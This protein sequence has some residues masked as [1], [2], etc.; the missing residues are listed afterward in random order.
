MMKLLAVFLYV[1]AFLPT[2]LASSS[3]SKST[4][5]KL[6]SG[7]SCSN[8]VSLSNVEATCSGYNCRLG[9]DL[10][11]TG[12]ITF[13]G[14]VPSSV[15]MT[16]TACFMGISMSSLCRTFSDDNVDLM[17]EMNL[18]STSSDNSYTFDSNIQVPGEE[19]SIGTGKTRSELSGKLYPTY[20][21]YCLF[22]NSPLYELFLF[23]F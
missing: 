11:A 13:P 3:E 9:D 12:S 4:Y 10:T 21:K 5:F 6:T 17:S 1:S 7:P 16:T 20:I 23:H 2:S 22:V 14:D 8:G 15:C 19:N 18:Q